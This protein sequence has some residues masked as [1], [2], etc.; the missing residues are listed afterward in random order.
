MADTER[1]SSRT[2][3]NQC[4]SLYQFLQEKKKIS[5]VIY[6]VSNSIH[7]SLLD[8]SISSSSSSLVYLVR[9]ALSIHCSCRTLIEC[10]L[11]DRTNDIKASYRQA[12]ALAR[13]RKDDD[14]QYTEYTK[15]ASRLLVPSCMSYL[16]IRLPG[17]FVLYVPT[18]TQCKLVSHS[19]IH[20][21]DLITIN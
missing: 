14:I 1:K 20:A 3:D 12:T 2:R 9:S 8:R 16:I 7:P 6:N 21:A 4:S 15:L 18:S 10:M 11:N 17:Y 5:S 19:V 13:N